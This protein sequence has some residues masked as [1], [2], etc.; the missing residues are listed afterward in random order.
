M[1]RTAAHTLAAIAVAAATLTLAAASLLARLTYAR[2]PI[3]EI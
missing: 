2:Q 1:T 3:G